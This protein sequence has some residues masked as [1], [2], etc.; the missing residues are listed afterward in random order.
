MKRILIATISA[1]LIA[2]AAQAAETNDTNTSTPA[3]SMMREHVSQS[4][5]NLSHR[6]GKFGVGVTFG[7]P[8]GVDMKY[9]LNETVAVDGAMGWSLHNHA[10]LYLQSDILWHDFHLLRVS[11]GQLP[12]Y[13]GIGA[14]VRFRHDNLDNQAG[15]RF[16]IGISYMFN[17]APVDI[18]AE[19]GPAI[20]LAPSVRGEITGGVGIRYWF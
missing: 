2:L 19:I 20:D 17:N 16:P 10:D 14:L 9:W 7:E 8:I 3:D 12:V 6:T 11:R 15:I 4:Y 13:A 5:S 18:F 1:M